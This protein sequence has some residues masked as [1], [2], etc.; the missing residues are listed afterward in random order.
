M[1]HD[2]RDSGSGSERTMSQKEGSV[3]ASER[4]NR[5]AYCGHTP[6]WSHL[7]EVGKVSGLH[8]WFGVISDDQRL[9]SKWCIDSLLL[10]IIA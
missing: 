9:W 8:F 10:S 4:A 5:Y 3:Q 1:K 2:L 7:T 6:I